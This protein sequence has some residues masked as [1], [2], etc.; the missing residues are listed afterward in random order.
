MVCLWGCQPKKDSVSDAEKPPRPV[1]IATLQLSGGPQ[2]KSVTAVAQSWKTEQIGFE[3]SGRIVWVAEPNTDIEGHVV[4]QNN[5]VII[6]GTPIARIDDEKYRL[7][8]EKAQAELNRADQSVIAAK[9]EIE[10]SIPSQIAAAKAD[11]ELARLEKERRIRLVA[12]NAGAQVD[13]D[14]A[15]ANY[16]NAAAK[17]E[18]LT[19]T[20]KAKQ[21]EL[22]SLKLQVQIAKQALK[23]A[24]RNL[25]NCV[26]FSSFRGQIADTDVVPGSVV[27]AGN[28]VA[29]VQLMNPMKVAFE[30]SPAESRRLQQGQVVPISVTMPDGKIEL[31]NGFVYS[32]DP[33][34]DPTTRTF[35][36]TVLL[37][38]ENIS[39]ADQNA[40]LPTIEQTW[41][42]VY[43]FLPGAKRGMRF[44][45][46]KVVLNDDK[47]DFV[48]KIDNLKVPQNPPADGILK[49]SKLRVTKLPLKLP[50]LG[51]WIFQQVRI[52]NDA[53]LNIKETLIAGRLT[54]SEQTTEPWNGTQVRIVPERRW[55]LRPG[56]LVKVDLGGSSGSTGIFV[57]INAIVFD[58]QKTYLMILSDAEEATTVN[59]VEVVM[60]SR[61]GD[62]AE[63]S[64]RQVTAKNG[65][66]LA[67][68]NFVVSGAHFLVDGQTVRVNRDQDSQSKTSNGSE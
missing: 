49:V 62:R 25:E 3:I 64:I 51:N 28:P 55:M 1:E 67:G 52:E 38:N 30:T 53:A 12:K 23:D 48:W 68:K 46:E 61:S 22:E 36:V 10:K 5:Q 42:L 13:A 17:V 57:P 40:T 58:Q 33:V 54:N 2:S 20:E 32:V 7:Q 39:Q 19:A 44:V 34:A 27:S 21:A 43:E 9:I 47:G 37:K 16:K 31:K 41:P 11:L 66:S 60:V 35:T 50:F 18:Q 59:R 15:V 24:N 63:S 65:E 8:V 4:D 29:T 56:D 6:Q 14:K 26:L 45:P